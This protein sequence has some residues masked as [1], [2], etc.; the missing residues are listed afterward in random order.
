M[1]KSWINHLKQNVNCLVRSSENL[2]EIYNDKCNREYIFVSILVLSA[3]LIG[4]L[5]FL[6]G[7]FRLQEVH[8]ILPLLSKGNVQTLSVFC[9]DLSLSS[10]EDFDTFEAKMSR[11]AVYVNSDG[12]YICENRNFTATVLK[13]VERQ[14]R[15]RQAEGKDGRQFLSC[16][17]ENLARKSGDLTVT[18]TRISRHQKYTGDGLNVVLHWDKHIRHSYIDPLI[19]YHNGEI[20][21]PEGRTY[22]VYLSA[23]FNISRGFT[24]TVKGRRFTLR[25]CRKVYGYEQTI[26]GKTELFYFGRKAVISSLNIASP[27]KLNR[28]D[29]IYVKVSNANMLIPYSSGTSFGL[30][31]L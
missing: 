22:F 17:N 5:V 25:I 20:T 26:L 29:K 24:S 6:V 16:G 14:S 11:P 1:I 12:K 31:P 7:Y 23:H 8:H 19:H 30:F 21:I 9:E 10:D 3:L 28:N 18:F 27:L 4:S 15:F 2:S 13:S